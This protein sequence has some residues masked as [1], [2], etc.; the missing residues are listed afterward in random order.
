M[1]R[2]VVLVVAAVSVI[3]LG[4]CSSAGYGTVSFTS[5]DSIV[6]GCQKIGDV[7]V[8]KGVNG[9]VT[10]QLAD[11]ARGKGANYVLR[12]SDDALSGTAYRCEAPRVASR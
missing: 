6:S 11:Q 12:S 3:S 2:I 5:S 10:A 1:K 8:E 7:A 4:A 9:D